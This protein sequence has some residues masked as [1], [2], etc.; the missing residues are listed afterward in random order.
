MIVGLKFPLFY[1]HLFQDISM[2]IEEELRLSIARSLHSVKIFS[3]E[4]KLRFFDI[5]GHKEAVFESQFVTHAGNRRRLPVDWHRIC[6]WTETVRIRDTEKI[7]ISFTLFSV[8]F[9]FILL[10]WLRALAE[11]KIEILYHN[12]KNQ[13]K[14]LTVFYTLAK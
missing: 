5:Q 1:L 12:I 6:S 3:F 2:C 11:K 7:I 4:Q 14:L 8:S 9:Q 10:E 13:S